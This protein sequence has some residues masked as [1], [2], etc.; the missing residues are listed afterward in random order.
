MQTHTD[1]GRHTRMVWRSTRGFRMR[2]EVFLF[3]MVRKKKHMALVSLLLQRNY[4]SC[5]D[6]HLRHKGRGSKKIL[7]LH[8][9]PL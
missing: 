6:S 4:C 5:T 9:N 2:E 7:R 3:S 1:T 8:L